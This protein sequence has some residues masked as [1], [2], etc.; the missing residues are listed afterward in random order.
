MTRLESAQ[1]TRLKRVFLPYD[2]NTTSGAAVNLINPHS[3]DIHFFD[4]ADS[5]PRICRF[6]GQLVL[7]DEQ[8]WTVAHH[9]VMG[10][11]LASDEILP[12]WLLHDA[13]EAYVGDIPRPTA[14]A[15]EALAGFDVIGLLRA[16]LDPVIHHKAGLEWPVPPHIAE[17]VKTLDDYM[18]S[19]E[20]RALRVPSAWCMSKGLA[21]L[22]A[23]EL[24]PWDDA[25]GRLWQMYADF[26]W[27]PEKR[28]CPDAVQAK[29][30]GR[31]VCDKEPPH[32]GA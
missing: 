12:Y 23:N 4:I 11:G 20:E 19:L 16:R 6:N 5:L 9:L 30:W 24:K 32:A 8:I 3:E 22:N 2:F 28:T 25:A 14:K 27:L 21:P 13:H 1:E 7:Q 31:R 26:G 10:S 18:L 29:L 17:Q 15:L